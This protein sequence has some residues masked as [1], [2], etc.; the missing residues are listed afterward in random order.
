MRTIE[1]ILENTLDLMT[2]E[3]A[4][5]FLTRKMK[6]FSIESEIT[7]ALSTDIPSHNHD[8]NVRWQQPTVPE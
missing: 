3:D 1:S 5:A 4:K 8:H 6:E 2:N 7:N